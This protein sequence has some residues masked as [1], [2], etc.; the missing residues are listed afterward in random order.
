MSQN[1][2]S[3]S[4]SPYLLMHAHQPVHWQEWGPGALDL[5][6]RFLERRKEKGTRLLIVYAGRDLRSVTADQVV[7]ELDAPAATAL[8]PQVP[9]HIAD[10]EKPSRL[11]RPWQIS[12]SLRLAVTFGSFWRTVPAVVLR[13]FA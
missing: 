4:V 12:F 7:L 2:L 13:A 3:Q 6:A 1:R 9:T 10:A 11:P 8:A 5:A